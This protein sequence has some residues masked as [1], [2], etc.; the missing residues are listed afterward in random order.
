MPASARVARTPSPVQ[1]DQSGRSGDEPLPF[2]VPPWSESSPGLVPCGTLA[3][4]C[5]PAPLALAWGAGLAG[6]SGWLGLGA[7]PGLTE[8][9][10]PIAGVGSKGTQPYP[11]KYTSVQAW[12][13]QF[14]RVA[15]PS[16]DGV[17]RVN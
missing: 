5:G 7:Q 1:I 4:T 10:T 14:V 15:T 2:V 17:P 6:W 8:P 3:E 16:G 9:A 12:R 13:L 11:W